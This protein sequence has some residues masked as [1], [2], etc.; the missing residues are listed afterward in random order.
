MDDMYSDLKIDEFEIFNVFLTI[1]GLSIAVF[2]P[3]TR[4]V[5]PLEVVPTNSIATHCTI[6]TAT[7]FLGVGGE[8]PFKL[9][10]IMMVTVA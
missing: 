7:I 3:T 9:L 8:R 10:G 4:A 1:L 6:C 5:P 2:S